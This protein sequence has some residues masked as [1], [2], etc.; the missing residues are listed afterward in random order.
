MSNGDGSAVRAFHDQTKHSPASL[1]AN[2]HSL[3]W[4]NQPL[5]FKIYDT[6]EP[7][8]LPRE[9]PPIDV[10]AL[11]AI[12]RVESATEAECIPDLTTLTQL[13]YYSAGI[14]RRITYPGGEIFYRAAACT[15]AL[16][17]VDLYVVCGDLPALAAGV[18]HFGP[19]DRSLRRLRAGDHRLTLVEATGEE[20]AVAAAPAILV[21]AS[22]YWRNAWKYQ[23]R[24]YRHCFWDTGTL[25]ANLLAIAAAREVPARVVAGFVDRA[26]ERLLDLDPGREAAI[27][28]VSLG[29]T[30]SRPRPAPEEPPLGLHTV[31]LSAREVAYPA[32]QAA[33]LATS[34]AT[35]DQVRAWRGRTPQAVLP[36]P[37]GSH[38]ALTP[39]PGAS[40]PRD[41]IDRVILRRGSTREFGRVPIGASALSTALEQAT[42][43][44]PADFL[45]PP[46]TSLNDIYVIVNAVEGLPAG[47]YVLQ[48][49][50]A[51][52][53]LLQEG[54]FRRD[55]GYLGLGQGIPA[56][57]SV[58]V[59]LL[60]DL[61]RALARYGDRGYRAAALEAGII[62]GRLYL[63]AYA[64]RVGA[65][66]LTF[67]DDDVT[68]FFSPH[69]R[70][71]SVLFLVALGI[72]AR[73]A[74]R[75]KT[76]PA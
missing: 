57:A 10:P 4:A 7:I 56:D 28:L 39:L 54:D 1:R 49:E 13:L 23:A 3:D 59:F 60:A 69:A 42:R 68:A 73:R 14:T 40:R 2:R 11:E 47:A 37:P 44:V 41:P 8:A 43:G 75:Q 53:G 26:V 15:G 16:Y 50:R 9:L 72:S 18:Y 71:K 52:L 19:H 5:P 29:H 38:F 46:G 36:P 76:T 30:R 6:L 33:H 48:R 17:H 25:L 20:P 22:T 35:P 70:G 55:A 24:A 51:A 45:E 58:D 34:L 21:C 66:G 62:G 61:D 67:F 64:Q 65:S 32:M 31:P 27:A 63:A 74:A 12:A